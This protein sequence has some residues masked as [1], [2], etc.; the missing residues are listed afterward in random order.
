MD[1]NWKT[2]VIVIGAVI[3][4]TAAAVLGW[5][6]LKRDVADHSTELA[7]IQKSISADHDLGV[8]HTAQIEGLAKTLDRIEHKLDHF[9][10]PETVTTTTTKTELSAHPP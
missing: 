4:L 1:T 2:I 6:S 7:V 3:S 8:A 5:A 10:A 9:R